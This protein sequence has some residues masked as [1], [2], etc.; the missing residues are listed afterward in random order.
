MV[1]VCELWQEGDGNGREESIITC[2]P[3]LHHD[4]SYH[5]HG[6]LLIRPLKSL[7]LCPTHPLLQ[8]ISPT[9]YQNS[10]QRQPTKKSQLLFQWA[11]PKYPK[12]YITGIISII[13]HPLSLWTQEEYVSRA[14]TSNPHGKSIVSSP[15]CPQV[16]PCHHGCASPSTHV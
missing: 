5:G 1:V 16:I 2:H 8:I 10:H 11:P 6:L 15:Q 7:S 9:P 13:H 14:P 3:S 12:A 4:K